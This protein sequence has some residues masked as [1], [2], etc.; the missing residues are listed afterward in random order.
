MFE[1]TT[2]V[3]NCYFKHGFEH[4]YILLCTEQKN[5]KRERATNF[6]KEEIRKLVEISIIYKT[7]L[8]NKKTDAVTWKEKENTWNEISR[9]F[10]SGN[11]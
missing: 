5:K 8:E 9:Q 11:T 3:L 2:V 4:T 1:D 10:N 7:I 6:S